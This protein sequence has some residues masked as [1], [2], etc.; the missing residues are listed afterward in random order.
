MDRGPA[1]QGL[2]NSAQGFNPGNPHNKG[3]A[4]KGREMRIPDEACSDLPCK[5]R[6]AQLGRATTGRSDPASALF[7]C[8]DLAPP[9]MRVALGGRFPGLKSWAEFRRPSSGARNNGSVQG[10]WLAPFRAVPN[11]Y[12]LEEFVTRASGN[13][14]HSFHQCLLNKLVIWARGKRWSSGFFDRAER[15]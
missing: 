12:N 10:L 15:D 11:S 14:R 4:L 3:F 6:S 7:G 9:S 2:Q 13:P 1:P 5:S 8:F